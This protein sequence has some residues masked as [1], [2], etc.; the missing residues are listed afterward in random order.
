MPTPSPTAI[1]I[2]SLFE[3][4]EE[5]EV[6]LSPV[7]LPVPLTPPVLLL[8]LAGGL[9]DVVGEAVTVPLVVTGSELD[10]TDCVAVGAESATC[11]TTIVDV[12]VRLPGSIFPASST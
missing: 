4:P 7:L 11:A 1:L 5:D 8:L 9:D 10:A 2:M 6:L 3:R 12:V